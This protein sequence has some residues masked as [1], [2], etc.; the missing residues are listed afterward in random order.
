MVYSMGIGRCRDPSGGDMICHLDRVPVP[1]LARTIIRISRRFASWTSTRSDK[2][3]QGRQDLVSATPHH[4]TYRPENHKG[5]RSD[6]LAKRYK[7]FPT[8]PPTSDNSE[9][10]FRT[11]VANHR[12]P[13]GANFSY[14]WMA[15]GEP[16]SIVPLSFIGN[17][18]SGSFKLNIVN[19]D[20]R[21]P[22]TQ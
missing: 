8:Q 19:T 22:L 14:G 7:A 18:L 10:N 11:R 2:V 12:E 15:E 17:H 5:A 21:A 13:W 6:R 16:W 4:V 3:R 9:I 1:S 20:G